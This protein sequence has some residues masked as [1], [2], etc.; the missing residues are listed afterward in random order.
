MSRST[1]TAIENSRSASVEETLTPKMSQSIWLKIAYFPQFIF[2]N[3]TI[4]TIILQSSQFFAEGRGGYRDNRPS[5]MLCALPVFPV[6]ANFSQ[7]GHRENFHTA[8]CAPVTL[9]NRSGQDGRRVFRFFFKWY[10]SVCFTDRGPNGLVRS[11]PSLY[12]IVISVVSSYWKGQM[13]AKYRWMSFNEEL[14]SFG[15]Q[16]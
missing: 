3:F 11:L 1:V 10:W 2:Q 12:V 6:V 13:S 15:S 16:C 14:A 7:R 8:T 5:R 4:I 9:G